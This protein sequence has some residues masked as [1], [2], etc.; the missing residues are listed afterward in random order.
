MPAT[1]QTRRVYDGTLFK[2]DVLSWTDGQGR[3]I[4]REVVRHPGAVTVVGVTGDDHVLMI[5]NRRV[6]VDERLC[7]LPAGK[8]E[9]G[10]P[11]EAAAVRELAEETGY[12]A[13]RVR[14]LGEFYTSPGFADEL[15]HV[16][17]AEG[18]EPGRQRLEP[19]EDINVEP[20]ALAAAL[21]MVRR[22]EIRDGKSIAALLMYWTFVRNGPE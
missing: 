2:V 17:V 4:R 8:L 16:Y 20:I 13:S 1:T 3:A 21:D 12:R 11:P 15:M 22:G 19:G 5:R 10:E 7:E 18:L 6:A 14:R 9:P